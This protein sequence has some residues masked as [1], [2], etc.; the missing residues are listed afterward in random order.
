MLTAAVDAALRR[1]DVLVTA[2]SL[3]TA[4]PLVDS[5]APA[6]WP[7]QSST[8]NV[9]GHPAMSVPIGLG[10]DGLPLAVQVVGRAFAEATVLRVGRALEKATGWDRVPLPA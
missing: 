2:I 9:T 1:H 7:L 8:F 10:R 5:T 6:A 3:A 4:P